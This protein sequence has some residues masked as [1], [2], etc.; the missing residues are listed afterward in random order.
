MR[1]LLLG[2][3]SRLH[4]TL[5]EGLQALG[6]EV[7]LVNNGDGFK[8]YPADISIRGRFFKSF[9]G[10]LL[11]RIWF[12]L[13]K[14]DLV[15][16]EHGV[17]FWK[18]LPKLKD[19]DVVQFIN[20]KPIQTIPNWEL[21]LIQAIVDQNANCFLL[22]CGV[23]TLNLEHMLAKKER[24]SIMNPYF[25]NP[26]STESEY[27]F[28]WEYQTPEH[29]KI[30]AFLL[31]YCKGIIASDLDYVAPL[32]NHPKFMGLI[33]N[34]VNTKNNSFQPHPVND[35]VVIFLGI[36][37][38]N[39]HTKGIRFFEEALAIVKVRW[40]DRAEII[41]STDIPY[42]EYHT[43]FEKAHILLD[44]VFAFD[45]GY[46]ALEAMAQGKVVFTGAETEFLNQYGLQENE[47]AINAL[48]DADY[49]AQQL[50]DLILHPEKIE[51]ISANAQAF[52]RQHHDYIAVAQQYLQTWSF[53]N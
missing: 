34:P 45:Q 20:E 28:M 12:R 31:E 33:P 52:I 50:G 39:Y 16:Y 13:F 15:V 8:N 22:S 24:Y 46:N 32:R 48:P 9:P 7:V 11:R 40:G 29:Q 49:L 17:R 43:Y 19:F 36:N 51:R 4:N 41:T 37:S 18:H 23:D 30:H 38:G 26:Q 44:Q 2:E 25:E 14:K 5:K 27:R 53:K 6:H 10:L 3:F 42:N 21:N 47:V 1:I 35:K